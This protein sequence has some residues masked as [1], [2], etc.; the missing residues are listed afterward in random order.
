[1]K[2][3]NKII[4]NVASGLFLFILALVL[5]QIFFRFVI[6]MS[7]PWTEEISRLTFVYLA[8]FGGAIALREGTMIVVDTVPNLVKG[9]AKHLLNLLIYIASL[10]YILIMFKG[11][12]YMVKLAWPTTLATVQWISNGWM[13]IAMVISFGLMIVY[14][15]SPIIN[16]AVQTFKGGNK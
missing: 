13:Y 15:I 10:I 14:S 12:L 5:A 4:D 3:F 9:R 7:V 6:R 2:T 1:M 16:S 11:S 8:F